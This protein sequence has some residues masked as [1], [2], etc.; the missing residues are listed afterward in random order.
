MTR[1]ERSDL[2]KLK[3][4]ETET[5]PGVQDQRAEHQLENW[6]LISRRRPFRR[7]R[8]NSPAWCFESCPSLPARSVLEE[9]LVVQIHRPELFISPACE[10]HRPAALSY[11]LLPRFSEAYKR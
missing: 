6:A 3:F 1:P 8:Q 5:A 2:T 9:A 4:G 11:R 7:S 10:C